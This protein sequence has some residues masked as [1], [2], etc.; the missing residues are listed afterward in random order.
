MPSGYPRGGMVPP[1]PSPWNS[2]PFIPS[3]ATSV[4]IAPPPPT[5]TSALPSPTRR[6][7]QQQFDQSV[8]S[9]L[10]GADPAK[11]KELFTQYVSIFHQYLSQFQQ[12]P[13]MPGMPGQP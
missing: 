13:A 1:T 4:R 9:S 11:K 5:P 6:M 8:G 10:E 7:L 3:F 12:N 2:K